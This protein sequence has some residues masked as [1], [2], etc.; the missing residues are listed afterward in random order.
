M[1]KAAEHLSA[2]P[3]EGHGSNVSTNAMML[4]DDLRWLENHAQQRGSDPMHIRRLQLAAALVGN[5]IHPFLMGIGAKDL[6]IA[7]VGGAGSGKSAVANLLLGKVI[8]ESNPQAG[9]TRHPIAYVQPGGAMPRTVDR[10]DRIGRLAK[11]TEPKPG[12]YD[13]DIYQVRMFTLNNQSPVHQRIVVW[14]CPDMTTWHASQ[15]TTRLLEVVGMTDIVIYVASD[16]RYNDSLP[17]QFLQMILQ[18]GKPVIAVLTK[19][20]EEHVQPLIEHFR[21]QVIAK[22]PECTRVA[23]CIGIPFM[24]AAA[25]TDP[26]GPAKPY[27][28]QLTE[29]LQW[30]VARPERTQTEVAR[31]AAKFIL[32]QQDELLSLA[33]SDLQALNAWQ[34]VV[35]DGRVDFTQR[36]VR[37]YLSGEQF[38]RF[39]AA[40]IRLLELL[41]VPGIGQYV[42]KALYV[43]RSPYRWIKSAVNKMYPQA[44]EARLPEEPVLKSALQQWLD[45]FH[46]QAA[47]EKSHPVWEQITSQVKEVFD[48]QA[49][50][51]FDQLIPNY[52]DQLNREVDVTARAIYED[53][54]KNPTA[55][56]ALRGTKLTLELATLGGTV[57][58]LGA[59]VVMNIVLLPL[60][61]ALTQELVEI[62]GK[63]YVDR[64]REKARA[65]QLDL[66]E[67]Q[68]VTPLSDWFL[69]WP[70]MQGTAIEKL[71]TVVE[72][73]PVLITAVHQEVTQK[74]DSIQS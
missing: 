45:R 47:L 6:Q 67:T 19:M 49:Q 48:Q 16:E 34:K 46:K 70:A 41:E 27:H 17:T 43:V 60:V 39:N 35:K 36:Y 66:F 2:E 9:F 42:S 72:R 22:L 23:A 4:V 71:T 21:S 74:G 33:K 63:Q 30:W 32:Q 44:P 69:K 40:L 54:E 68:V 20:K 31:S 37:E 10:N 5:H 28:D 12:D 64:Q 52:H 8:A 25:L 59:H 62:F 65:R 61:A 53:L 56:N 24:S 51:Q 15:Y 18:C 14:D 50:K 73:V 3:R 1:S 13:H 7:I 26:A 29:T 11:L 55:L 58:F 57:V 38:P